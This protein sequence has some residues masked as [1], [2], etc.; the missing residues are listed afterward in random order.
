MDGDCTRGA[1][2]DSL[3]ITD[4]VT[5][6][7]SRKTGYKWLR[8]HAEEG[9]PGLQDRSHAPHHCPHRLEPEIAGLILRAR[10]RHPDWGPRKLL[11][12]LAPRHPRISS[13]PAVS[14]TGDLLAREGLVKKRRRRRPRQH[15]G[16]VPPTTEAATTCGPPTSRASF[17]PETASGAS[18]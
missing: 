3:P 10:R 16:A 18:P 1:E 2:S 11:A 5:Y 7:I 14:T 17:P 15:P 4:P 13:W 8:R 6:G 9:Q 12:W